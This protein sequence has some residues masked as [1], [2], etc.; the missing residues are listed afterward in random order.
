MIPVIDLAMWTSRDRGSRNALLRQID[1]AARDLGFMQV[2]GHGID[3]RV[4]SALQDA[5]DGFFSLSLDEKQRWC[6]PSAE[7]N[8]G[9]SSALSE[10]L[11]YSAGVLSAADLFEAFN[12]GVSW[13]DFPGLDLDP[14]SY[15]ENI[16]PD[17]PAHFRAGVE[18]WFT[19]AGAFA[20]RLTRLFA[21]ALNL[22]EDYFVPYEDHSVDVLRLNHYALPHGP[23][24]LEPGQMGMG[25]H[26]DFGMV[27]V[28]W[29]DPVSPGLQVQGAE[30]SWID[31]TPQPHA[32]LVNLGDLMARWT[33]GRWTSSLHR[34]LPPI[35]L[36]GRVSRRRSAAYF[37]DGNADATISAL[38]SCCGSGMPSP[39]EPITVAEHLRRKL[40]GSRALQV[41]TA[42]QSESQRIRRSAQSG[43]AFKG[44]AA[45]NN[46]GESPLEAPHPRRAIGESQEPSGSRGRFQ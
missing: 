33:N 8:R 45:I 24:E 1:Q 3:W 26:T 22:P 12:L 23:I 40:A 15:P 14:F 7:I 27:T 25:A 13:K 32:L 21:L 29:A 18:A 34:V 31:V 46:S 9:Y 2:L 30:G 20:R 16:W 28:L 4:L 38:P 11:S 19:E 5:M 39:P 44:P 6:A 10:R 17:E 42:A 43:Q 35:D 36:E 41:N 37:H